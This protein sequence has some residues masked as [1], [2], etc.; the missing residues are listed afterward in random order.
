MHPKFLLLIVFSCSA[1]AEENEEWVDPWAPPG[2]KTAVPGVDVSKGNCKKEGC[3]VE[4][5]AKKDRVA[6]EKEEKT[7]SQKR[8]DYLFLR[9][10]VNVWLHS[11]GDVDIEREAEIISTGIVSK[12]DLETLRQFSKKKEIAHVSDVAHVMEKIFSKVHVKRDDDMDYETKDWTTLVIGG[13][14][15]IGG[16]LVALLIYLALKIHLSWI[17]IITCLLV[18]LWLV[19]SVWEWRN[20]YEESMAKKAAQQ[21]KE[22]PPECKPQTGIW[23]TGY[24]LTAWVRETFSTGEDPCVKYHKA[25]LVNPASEAVPMKVNK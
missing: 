13:L 12:V 23:G 6:D 16:C 7:T 9:R 17:K 15:L 11:L 20:L 25:F 5:G 14:I 18:I 19:S 10:F 21:M 2:M 24:W 4:K 8:P 22:M 3:V 1:V